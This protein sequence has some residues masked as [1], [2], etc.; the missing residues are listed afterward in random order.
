MVNI[1]ITVFTSSPPWVS[2]YPFLRYRWEWSGYRIDA[3]PWHWATGPRSETMPKATAL[4]SRGGTQ[5]HLQALVRPPSLSQPLPTQ[6]HSCLAESTYC[7]CLPNGRYFFLHMQNIRVD[8]IKLHLRLNYRDKKF[9][10]SAP[11]NCLFFLECLRYFPYTKQLIMWVA[12]N[13]APII[14]VGFHFT[15]Y[16]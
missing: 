4:S 15:G 1:I 7:I 16:K 6:H 11:I 2:C 3:L 12:L 5:S 10:L 9:N 13:S 8:L 14:L